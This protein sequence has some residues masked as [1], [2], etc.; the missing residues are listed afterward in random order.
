MCCR[1]IGPVWGDGA[2]D[3]FEQLLSTKNFNK[4]WL[5]FSNKRD[6]KLSETWKVVKGENGDDDFLICTGNPSGYL[7]TIKQYD[8]FEFRMEWKYPDLNDPNCNSGILMHT[9]GADKIWP[10]AIQLQ[11]HRPTA[12]NI[13]AT[14]GAKTENMLNV[15]NLKLAVNQWHD[16]AI[17]SKDGTI[18]V[19]INGKQVGEVTGCVPRKGSIALQSEG[20]EIHFRKI[21]IRELKQ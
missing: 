14:G 5:Q 10:K 6:G 3:S 1:W 19:K 4:V 9:S 8:N 20:S 11:L 7:R 2:P 16:C 17:T 21:E 18:S 13:F 15:K 12:G